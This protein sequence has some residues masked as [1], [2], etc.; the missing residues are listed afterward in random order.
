MEIKAN[1]PS[2][3]YSIFLGES[4]WEHILQI[5]KKFQ[6]VV[7]CTDSNLYTLYQK[8]ILTYFSPEELFLTT[9]GEQSKNENEKRKIEDFLFS[10]QFPKDGALI[11]LGGG[12]LLDLGGFVASTYLRGI[13]FFSIPSTLLAMVDASIGGKTAI[14]TRWGKNL[15]GTIY[16]PHAIFVDFSFLSTLSDSL[17]RDGL[18]EIWKIA[19]VWDK[20]LYEW[21]LQHQNKWREKERNFFYGIIERSIVNKLTITQQDEEEKGI[22]HL[23]NFGH[24]IGHAL[25]TASGF[26]LSHGEAVA[27]GMIA[28]IEISSSFPLISQDKKDLI[29]THLSQFQMIPNFPSIFCH[30]TFYTSLYQDKKRKKRKLDMVLLQDIGKATLASQKNITIE[31]SQVESSLAQIEKVCSQVS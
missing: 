9:P 27:L 20:E 21:I 13:P 15:L 29:Y 28:E 18:S 4:V 14:N 3:S 31:P 25:E 19:L 2:Q 10:R 12:A 1:F 24:T 30:Q 8:Q 16:H 17:F 6:D 26:T 23:L 11:L 5:R 22:R 7:L